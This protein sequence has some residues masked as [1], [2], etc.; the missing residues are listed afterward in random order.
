MENGTQPVQEKKNKVVGTL[1]AEETLRAENVSLRLQNTELLAERAHTIMAALP[2]MRA[3]T[4]S[5]STALRDD[6]AKRLGVADS[7]KL[8]FKTTGEVELVEE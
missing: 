3:E 2:S 5:L 4:R 1:T 7:S 6:V 8:V